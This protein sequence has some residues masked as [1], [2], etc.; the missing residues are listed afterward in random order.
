[1][2]WAASTWAKRDPAN[3]GRYENAVVF[4]AR[5][6]PVARGRHRS[7]GATSSARSWSSFEGFVVEQ[8][9]SSLK[10]Q[11]AYYWATHAGAELDLLILHEGKRYGFECKFADA[12]GTTRSMRVALEDLGLE[13]L[14]VVYPG[15]E[16]YVL[17]D[18]IS[19]LPVAE[20]GPLTESMM[21]PAGW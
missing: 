12:P 17:D 18:R 8:L 1:M 11:D 3:G 20:I 5:F 4:R 15:D 6:S 7:G 19:A 16:G 9:L 21:R 13:H 10:S 2:T 14:W